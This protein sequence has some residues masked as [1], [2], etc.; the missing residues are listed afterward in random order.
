LMCINVFFF[1]FDFLFCW[2]L[3]FEDFVLGL[4]GELIWI[5]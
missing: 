3:G 1:R 5:L 2:R 4:I